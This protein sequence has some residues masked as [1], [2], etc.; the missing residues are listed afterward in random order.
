MILFT[1]NKSFILAN[2]QFWWKSLLKMLNNEE[3]TLGNAFYTINNHKQSL[4][5]HFL[6]KSPINGGLCENST[7]FPTSGKD[8]EESKRHWDKK[9]DVR[10]IGWS[11]NNLWRHRICLREVS[12]YAIPR[13][14]RL[15]YV[16]RY[17][18]HVNCYFKKFAHAL[19]Y[20]II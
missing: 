16:L 17:F 4:Y 9:L 6:Q 14:Y 10:N 11:D 20:N 13:I 7:N 18:K 2:C 5:A 19:M 12:L 3:N 8:C 1:Q 15:I